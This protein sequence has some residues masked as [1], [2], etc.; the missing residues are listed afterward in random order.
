MNVYSKQLFV[1]HALTGEE[2][3]GPPDGYVWVIRDVA[4]YDPSEGGGNEYEL[5]VENGSVVTVIDFWH[6]PT[7]DTPNVHQWK[8]HQVVPAGGG[9]LVTAVTGLDVTISGYELT[10]P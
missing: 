6:S 8:G 9:L 2:G 10:L 4:V 1:V 3:A 7:V 5:E